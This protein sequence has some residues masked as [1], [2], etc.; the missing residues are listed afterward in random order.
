MEEGIL[1]TQPSGSPHATT[2]EGATSELAGMTL[3]THAS[4]HPIHGT[5]PIFAVRWIRWMRW[6][7]SAGQISQEYRGTYNLGG[8]I[9]PM[10]RRPP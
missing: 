7:A 9:W 5:N 6:G 2:G 1:F 3:G 10:K 8:N 4:T